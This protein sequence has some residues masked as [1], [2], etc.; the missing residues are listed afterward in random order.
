MRFD[1]SGRTALVTGAAHGFGRAIALGLAR[2]GAAVWGC[3]LLA[4]EL[5]ETRALCGE[6]C[7]VRRLDVTDRAA[8]QRLAAEVQAATGR[9]D[10]LVNDAGGV[11]GQ[12]HRP[13][14]SVPPEDW[15]AIFDVNVTGAFYC[16]QA[17]APAMK[18]ARYGRIVNISSGAGL[19]TSLTGIQAYAAAKAA[20]IGLT[21]QLAQ[22]LGAWNITVNNVAPGFVRSNPTTERQWESYGPEGQQKLVDGLSLKRLGSADDIAAAVLFFASE[23]AGWITGQ[24]LSVDGGRP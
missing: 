18:A 5:D 20:Q 6:L 8:V 21:R 24:V 1:F 10:I 13:I 7:R 17:V 22:E 16:S 11:L 19:R 12:T 4:D 2:A 23:E 9:I 15:Q 3:D 14:E